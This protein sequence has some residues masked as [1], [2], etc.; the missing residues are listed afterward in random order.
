M[1]YQSLERV[2]NRKIERE[3]LQYKSRQALSDPEEAG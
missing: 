2:Q 3:V 1:R